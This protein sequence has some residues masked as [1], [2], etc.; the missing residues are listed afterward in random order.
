[1]K[2]YINL[3][4]VDDDEDDYLITLDALDDVAGGRYRLE[5]CATYSEGLA[6][7]AERRHDAYLFDYHIGAHT[8]LELLAET[9]TL[10]D[11]PIIMLTGMSD[12]EVDEQAIK[13]GAADYLVKGQ[14]SGNLLDRSIR[15][16]FERQ[17]MQ[18]ALSLSEE[19]YAIAAKGAND[20]LWDWRLD[21]GEV[22]FS[23]RW[24]NMLG[25]TEAE[26][27]GDLGEWLD[28]IH[29]DDRTRVEE[30]IELHQ[31]GVTPKLELE[32]RMAT[33]DG[34]WRWMLTRGLAVRD[35]SGRVTRMTGWQTDLSE[36]R[37]SYD[38][39]TSLPNRSLFF[40]RLS[41]AVSRQARQPAYSYAVLFLDLD[42]F[43]HVNDSLGHAAG[44]ALLLEAAARLERC[45]RPSD[46][47]SRVTDG[48]EA[49]VEQDVKKVR[50]TVARFG[51]DE[52]ALLVDNLPD[53]DAVV[54][55]AERIQ[56]ALVATL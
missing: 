1:M 12:P 27:G 53:V 4:L 33:K 26:I 44:D 17:K 30:D 54:G 49:T 37:A 6:A 11:A 29:P 7:V 5:W 51:G 39:L 41:R 35:N 47:V 9:V 21:T 55:I 13:L 38:A 28:R 43:K 48:Q 16:A 46:T 15:H 42:S 22:Y 24:K 50:G 18:R 40:D 36:R 34:C 20:G 10:V 45:V 32:Y 2:D 52:F 56:D 19:R 3:L 8:G 25:Y 31:S 14:F 23:A